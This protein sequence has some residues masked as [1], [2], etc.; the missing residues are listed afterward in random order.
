ME[1]R[2]INRYTKSIWHKSFL[3]KLKYIEFSGELYKLLENYLPGRILWLSRTDKLHCGDLFLAGISQG[4][5]MGPLLFLF[6]KNNLLNQ[7]KPNV[8]LF[9]DNSSIFVF[10]KNNNETANILDNELLLI[11]T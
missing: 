8:K 10:V 9:A 3:Y 2:D 1:S 7:L 6:H 5:I 4:S 11:S